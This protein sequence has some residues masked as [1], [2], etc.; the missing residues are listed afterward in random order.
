MSFP[1]PL[2]YIC[3]SIITIQ[4]ENWNTKHWSITIDHPF[5]NHK[6]T[7]VLGYNLTTTRNRKQKYTL[8]GN[9]PFRTIEKVFKCSQANRTI[10]IQT[11][12][13]I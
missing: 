7:H 3:S 4:T 10:I 12:D 6:N 13:G 2:I 8:I 9:H 11:V 5:T 1:A